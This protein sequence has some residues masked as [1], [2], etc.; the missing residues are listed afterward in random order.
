[1]K[2]FITDV[3]PLLRENVHAKQMNIHVCVQMN[4][5]FPNE[6]VLLLFPPVLPIFV[7]ENELDYHQTVYRY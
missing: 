3:K 4:I 1:M 6:N 5:I 2:I 7:T